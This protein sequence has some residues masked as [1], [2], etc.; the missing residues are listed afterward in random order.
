MDPVPMQQQR[1]PPAEFG[2][3]LGWFHSIPPVTRVYLSS[4]F[5]L[6][7][8]THLDLASPFHLYFNP[9]LIRAGEWWRLVT[10]FAY[11]G[12]FSVDF[13]FHMYFLVRYSRLLEE[14]DFRGRTSEF[15][16]MLFFGM[17]VMSIVGLYVRVNFLGSSLTFMMVYVW[18]R[19]NKLVRM[20][21][22]G[23]FP[24]TAPWLPWVMLG[25]S[26]M[27]GNPMTI[28]VIGIGVGH[29]YF[30]LAFV[31]PRL[32]E[33]RGWKKKKLLGAPMMLQWVCGE[34]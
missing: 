6:T 12:T 19:R 31:Y 25:F 9:K 30:F 14:G 11:F 29:M 17:F 4:S 13:L 8:L 33:I 28:D 24:F 16:V 2:N 23:L 26:V 10:N 27:L 22:L 21:F 20:S 15:A 3:L 34:I 18:G 7:T 32:A 5:L 1:Q